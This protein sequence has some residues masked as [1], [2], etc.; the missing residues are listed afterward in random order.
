MNQAFSA[1]LERYKGF[2]GREHFS[3]AVRLLGYG[4][5]AMC[6]G[7]ML[8]I[9]TRNVSALSILSA[10]V[11]PCLNTACID[12]RHVDALCHIAAS[13]HATCHQATAV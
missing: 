6:V 8:D 3:C 1:L 13:G 11:W 12:P 5:V 9:V 2:V 10:V 4:G 7:E